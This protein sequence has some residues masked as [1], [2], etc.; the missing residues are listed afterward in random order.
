MGSCAT[1]KRLVRRLESRI[2]ASKCAEQRCF[3]ALA[4][5]LPIVRLRRRNR[6][7][8][9]LCQAN[10]AKPIRHSTKD[11]LLLSVCS[12]VCGLVQ[13]IKYV[14]S[15]AR[16]IYYRSVS[17]RQSASQQSHRLRQ[18]LLLLLLLSCRRQSQSQRQCPSQAQLM[19]RPPSLRN[20]HQLLLAQFWQPLMLV[21]ARLAPCSPQSSLPVPPFLFNV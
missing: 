2:R 19:S 18:L 3:S 10:V 13:N 7:Q 11:N 21:P 6:T 5:G 12:S 14:R 1:S 20:R 8:T 16:P 9:A 15:A 17:P 4:T